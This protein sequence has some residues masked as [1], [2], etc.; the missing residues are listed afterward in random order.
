MK[1]GYYWKLIR[2]KTS[3][4]NP[5]KLNI[6]H[7]WAV[8]QSWIR[9]LFPISKHIKEQIVWRR[10]QVILKSPSCWQEGHCI[11]CGCEILPKTTSDLGCE[12]E[13]FCYPDMMGKAK[14]KKYKLTND[15][16]LFL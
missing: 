13:P 3:A 6:K 9:S 16:K 5:A 14:W 12:N 2:G 1:L 10:G 15:I 11:Q 7:I 4:L 8:I